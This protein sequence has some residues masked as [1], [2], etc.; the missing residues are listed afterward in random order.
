MNQDR[1]YLREVRHIQ[2]H[3]RDLA[4]MDMRTNPAGGHKTSAQPKI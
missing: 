1:T 4:P 2:Q 3:T